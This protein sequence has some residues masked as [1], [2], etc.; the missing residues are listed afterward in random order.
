TVTNA[1]LARQ[2]VV[3]RLGEGAPARHFAAVSTNAKASDAFLIPP[4]N[5]FTMWDWVGGRYS[6]WSAV[7][8]SV[9]LA[10]GMDQFELMLEGGYEIGQHFA[11]VR[12]RQNLAVV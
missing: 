11:T 5:R 6:V 4:P 7:G 9:A 12:W 8:L 3:D 1:K 10:L 2:W